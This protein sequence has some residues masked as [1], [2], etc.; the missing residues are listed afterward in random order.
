MTWRR[1]P[2]GSTRGRSRR[3][4]TTASAIGWTSERR[5]QSSRCSCPASA[6]TRIAARRSLKRQRRRRRPASPIWRLL[7]APTCWVAAPADLSAGAELRL[8]TG[9]EEDLLGTGKTALRVLAIGSFEGTRAS[10]H[11]NGGYSWGGISREANYSAALT[12]AASE[13][14]TLVGEFLGR[15]IEGLGQIG[16]VTAPHPSSSGVDTIRLLPMATGTTTGYG[17]RGVQVECRRPL[18][19]QRQRI[20][21]GHRSR[22][23]RAHRPRF[24]SG[25]F[26]RRLVST[27]RYRLVCALWIFQPSSTLRRW[28]VHCRGSSL[29]ARL[30]TLGV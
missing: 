22:P 23:A 24:R 30:P 11:L 19:R 9:R 18:A 17:G 12:V 14:F 10:A 1:S 15:W 28:N 20:V 27:G 13:R 8:P 7:R 6:S 4:R 29:G 25:L 16:Q 5:C 2:S 26:V 3:S 21:A